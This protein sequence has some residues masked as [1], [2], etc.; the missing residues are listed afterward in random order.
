[1]LSPKKMSSSTKRKQSKE[2]VALPE[3][4]KSDE[5]KNKSEMAKLAKGRSTSEGK[6]NLDRILNDPYLF[7]Q[8]YFT[9]INTKLK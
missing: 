4:R 2:S 1:M 8:D 3:I 7:M 6:M 5:K 9:D